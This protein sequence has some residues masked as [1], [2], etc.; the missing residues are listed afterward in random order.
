ML[1]EY[2]RIVSPAGSV[3]CETITNARHKIKELV[4]DG[5]TPGQIHLYRITATQIFL[6][7]ILQQEVIITTLIKTPL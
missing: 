2:Y 6:N 7:D 4:W 5:Y 3:D 1:H